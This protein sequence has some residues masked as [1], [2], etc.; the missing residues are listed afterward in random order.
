MKA[1]KSFEALRR[2]P[3]RNI[4]EDYDIKLTSLEANI[5]SASQEISHFLWKPK[6]TAM[7]TSAHDV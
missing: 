3:Q 2:I 5:G 1:P 4:S 6:L 7:F